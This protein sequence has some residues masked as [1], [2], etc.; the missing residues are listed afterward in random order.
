MPLVVFSALPNV[1]TFIGNDRI[2]WQPQKRRTILI[3]LLN[4]SQNTWVTTPFRRRN[5]AIFRATKTTQML[6]KKTN[7]SGELSD[8][9]SRDSRFNPRHAYWQFLCFTEAKLPSSYDSRPHAVQPQKKSSIC[10]LTPSMNTWV[11]AT[12]WR[13]NSPIFRAAT[14]LWKRK[15][16]HWQ[17]PQPFHAQLSV[18]LEKVVPLEMLCQ[19]IKAYE[20]INEGHHT[21]ATVWSHTFM[22][23]AASGLNSGVSRNSKNSSARRLRRPTWNKTISLALQLGS[24]WRNFGHMLNMLTRLHGWEWFQARGWPKRGMTCASNK[25]TYTTR[26]SSLVCAETH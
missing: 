2:R 14:T 24:L 21:I 18:H 7:M 5:S 4:P 19:R 15:Y 25:I 6:T 22:Y 8:L 26:G 16:A 10:W 11:T 12:C 13:R 23:R 3:C 17:W 9:S 20:Q 1:S